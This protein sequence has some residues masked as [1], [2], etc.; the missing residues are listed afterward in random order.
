MIAV[1]RGGAQKAAADEKQDRVFPGVIADQRHGA[2]GRGEQGGDH[3][4]EG[5]KLDRPL[6]RGIADTHVQ[7]QQRNGNENVCGGSAFGPV[8]TAPV[9]FGLLLALVLHGRTSGPR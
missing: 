2:Y 5:V 1:E 3:L 6:P 9:Y 4:H 7:D 8:G